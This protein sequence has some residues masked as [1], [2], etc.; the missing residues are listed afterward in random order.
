LILQAAGTEMLPSNRNMAFTGSRLMFFL[1]TLTKSFRPTSHLHNFFTTTKN[2]HHTQAWHLIEHNNLTLIILL[3]Y[4]LA[5]S[6]T[7]PRCSDMPCLYP[8][9]SDGL[10]ARVAAHLGQHLRW[11]DPA[12]PI[13]PILPLLHPA[14]VGPGTSFP[15]CYIL[16]RLTF[17]GRNPSL[18]VPSRLASS[19]FSC[20]SWLSQR[21]RY[22]RAF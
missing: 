19:T 16:S 10:T 6:T 3:Y 17:F 9:G 11:T 20:S 5:V 2:A 8:V 12:S 1:A 21:S 4:S 18:L 7:P 22:Q 14:P 13:V 15:E